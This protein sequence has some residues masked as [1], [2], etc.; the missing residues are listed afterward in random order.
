MKFA[1]LPGLFQKAEAVDFSKAKGSLN[2]H[3]VF[4]D[5]KTFTLQ[6]HH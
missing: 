3:G 1:V 4:L 2:I 5:M 6:E